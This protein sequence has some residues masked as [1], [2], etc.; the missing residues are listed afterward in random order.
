[1]KANINRIRGKAI[2][3]EKM[4]AKETSDKGTLS[5]I[6]KKLLKLNK[7]KPNTPIFKCAKNPDRLPKNIQMAN[8]HMKRCSTSYVI[9]EMQIKTI[10]RY[11]YTPIRMAK[12]QNTDNTKF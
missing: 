1:M 11:H 3:W 12:I 7:K 10:M 9:R 6:Y 2:E 8:N 5:K 4:F